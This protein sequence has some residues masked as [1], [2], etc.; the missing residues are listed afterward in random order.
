MNW[1]DSLLGVAILAL[2]PFVLAAYGGHVAAQALTDRRDRRTTMLKFWGL[3]LLGI[4]VAVVYQFRVA[5]VDQEQ[6][7][8]AAIADKERQRKLD[9]AQQQALEAQADLK[10]IE[11]SNG[12]QIQW[13]QRRLDEVISSAQSQGQQNAAVAL[14]NDLEAMKESMKEAMKVRIEPH[15]PT[16]LVTPSVT[17]PP[18]RPCRGDNLHDCSDEELLEWGKP[19]LAAVDGIVN[20]H[21]ADLKALDDIKGGNWM[22]F[23]VGQDKDSK[24]LRAHAEAQEKAADG[25]RDC[26][27]ES[28]LNYHR[29][30]VQRLG[31]GTD[32]NNVYQWVEKLLKSTKS[33]DWKEARQ[34]AGGRILD[35]NYDLSV[36]SNHLDLK[37]RLS[38]I[39]QSAIR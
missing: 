17:P 3:C 27:A 29:E 36:L 35:I 22:S 21:M 7:L 25:F 23:L 8:K 39:K 1:I 34:D 6:Q 11:R 14:R 37:L 31:G 2:V 32:K 33:K 10:A 30:L 28:T 38:K 24:W 26:C 5:K 15:P 16:I 9:V 20:T 12:Q 13:L 4:V 19:L 18:V